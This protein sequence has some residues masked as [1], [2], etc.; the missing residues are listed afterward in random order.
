[1]KRYS[2]DFVLDG[3]TEADF[4]SWKHHPVTKMFLRYLRDTERQYAAHQVGGLRSTKG[5]PDPFELGK[6]TG[7][8]NAI[9]EMAEPTYESIVNFYTPEQQEEPD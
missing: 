8:I 9:A 3:I 6:W 4:Q 2:A 1:M 5:T 7:A